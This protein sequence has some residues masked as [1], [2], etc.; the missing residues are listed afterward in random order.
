MYRLG[1]DGRRFLASREYFM[2]YREQE[3]VFRDGATPGFHEGVGNAMPLA[4]TTPKHME[5]ILGLD[6]GFNM[7]CISKAKMG[8]KQAEPTTPQDIN[9][10]YSLALEKVR[11]R[12]TIDIPY[13][14]REF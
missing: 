10:L 12:L 1:S 4:I 5:C 14:I 13:C 2:E 7:T 9:Y 11:F 8:A 6:L 3:Y